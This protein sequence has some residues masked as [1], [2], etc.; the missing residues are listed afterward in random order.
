MSPGIIISL[1]LVAFTGGSL[2]YSYHQGKER[3]EQVREA[4][5]LAA[6]LKKTQTELAIVDKIK[7]FQLEQI[8]E[9]QKNLEESQNA[10]QSLQKRLDITNFNIPECVPDSVLDAIRKFRAKSKGKHS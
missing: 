4:E 8:S 1:L 10:I 6:E 5:K 2:F 7:D 9:A 3:G